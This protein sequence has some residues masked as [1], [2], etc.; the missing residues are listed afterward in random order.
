LPLSS[1]TIIGFGTFPHQIQ[2]PLGLPPGGQISLLENGLAAQRDRASPTSLTGL[3]TSPL[4]EL[5]AMHLSP[6]S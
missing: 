1:T 2:N 3:E 5:E 4:I 6:D